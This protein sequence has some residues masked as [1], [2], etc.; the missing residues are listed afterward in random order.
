LCAVLTGKEET[1]GIAAAVADHS[2]H[3]YARTLER[4]AGPELEISVPPLVE[5]PEPEGPRRRPAGEQEAGRA[6]GDRSLSRDPEG[7]TQETSGAAPGGQGTGGSGPSQSTPPPGDQAA[8]VVPGNP[9][10]GSVPSGRPPLGLPRDVQAKPAQRQLRITIEY[11]AGVDGGALRFWKGY[12][13]TD[14]QVREAYGRMAFLF[15]SRVLFSF[16]TRI[17]GEQ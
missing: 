9:G 6:P 14:N 2:F 17:V 7:G 3:Q 1:K 5:R 16:D 4:E 10:A 15:I 13:I 8:A 12:A 11:F